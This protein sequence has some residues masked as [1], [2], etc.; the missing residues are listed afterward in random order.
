[1]SNFHVN[2]FRRVGHHQTQTEGH[3]RNASRFARTHSLFTKSSS[4][5]GS[6]NFP[7]HWSPTSEFVYLLFLFLLHIFPPFSFILLLLLLLFKQ[8]NNVVQWLGIRY[9]ARSVYLFL[10]TNNTKNILNPNPI[11]TTS[12]PNKRLPLSHTTFQ[13]SLLLSSSPLFLCSKKSE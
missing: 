6:V 12:F 11:Y 1:L 8:T 10:S 7:D 13:I 9:S 2:S 4:W 5:S 3:D